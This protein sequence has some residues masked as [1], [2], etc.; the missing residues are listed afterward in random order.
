MKLQIKLIHIVHSSGNQRLS[1]VTYLG[2]PREFRYPDG[3]VVM[4]RMRVVASD[5]YASTVNLKKL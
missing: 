5:Q 3:T 4:H 1:Y 2:A